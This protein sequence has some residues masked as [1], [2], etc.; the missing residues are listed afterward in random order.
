[1]R[2]L[3]SVL[4][5]LCVSGCSVVKNGPGGVAHQI[6]VCTSELDCKTRLANECPK[7]GVLYGIKQAVE[8]EYSCNQ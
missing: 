4:C 3:M 6:V 8:I 7:G 5:L 1:M 2:V